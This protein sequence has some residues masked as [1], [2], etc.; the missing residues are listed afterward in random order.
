MGHKSSLYYP[1]YPQDVEGKVRG[2]LVAFLMS[3][4]V[5]FAHFIFLFASVQ[6]SGGVFVCYL[7]CPWEQCVCFVPTEAGV[8]LLPMALS[9]PS[10]YVL[11]D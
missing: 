3:N 7:T 1:V 6:P 4:I 8:L 9:A 10:T 5:S 2:K 11:Q